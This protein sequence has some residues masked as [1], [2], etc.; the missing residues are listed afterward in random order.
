MTEQEDRRQVERAKEKLRAKYSP[1][2]LSHLGKLPHP[3]QLFN[4][5]ERQALEELTN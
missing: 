2:N 5:V 3:E 4:R 1:E